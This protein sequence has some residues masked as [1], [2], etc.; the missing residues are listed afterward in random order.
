[1]DWG[2]CIIC[3]KTKHESLQCPANSTRKDPG[4]GYSTFIKAVKEFKEIGITVTQFLDETKHDIENVLLENKASWQKSCRDIYNSTKLERAKKKRKQADVE[5]E[6]KGCD[7]DGSETAQS[8][9]I[10]SRR[11]LTH[12]DPK[13][14]QCFFCEKNDFASNLR[15]A[16]T[17][18]LDKKVRECAILLNDS[19]LIAKLSTGDLIAVEAK[20]HV[21]CLVKLYNRARPFKKECSDAIDS[22]SVDLE[23]LAFAELIGYIEECLEQEAPGVL[24]LSELV[25]FYQCKLKE[26][27]AE[28]GKTNATRLKERVLEA[29]PDLMA[30]RHDIGGILTEAKRRDSDAWC[31]ARAAHIVR[32][33][34]LNVDNS[35]NGKFAPECQK[36]SIPASLL[37]FVGMLIKGP[38]TKIDP[39]NNQ[40]CVSVSQ[41]IVFNSVARPRHRSEATGSTHHIRS[42]ECPLPIYTALKIHGATRDRGLIDAFYNL[43]LSISYDRFLTVSTE[44]T[45]SVIDR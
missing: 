11:S 20:Y 40:A 9:P 35:F 38:T 31:L 8:S 14:L 23:E 27:G 17:L 18:E 32:K 21:V 24:T 4:I 45:N 36:N 39:S 19:K 37:S 28:S 16:S 33:D 34:I 12:F 2:K 44:I 5:E 30:S 43:G 15:Y 29:V 1:M 3:Q 13:I 6:E 25:K 10:K 26:V 41:L 7:A 22:S 42:R